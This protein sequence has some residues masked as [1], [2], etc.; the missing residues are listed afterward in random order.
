[1]KALVL[2]GYG[3][4]GARICRALANDPHI[5]LLVGGRD[6]GQA[7]KLAAQLGGSAQGVA[8]DMRAPGFADRLRSLGIELVIHTA[9]PF[10]QQSYDVPLAIAQA[11]LFSK[12][13]VPPF[14]ARALCRPCLAP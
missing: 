4:F 6:L 14:A 13:A 11:R 1:M 3:N 7:R 12:L 9:G 8:L 5:D 2:G 10:Q